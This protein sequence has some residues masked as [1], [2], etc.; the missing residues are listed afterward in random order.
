MFN[1]QQMKTVTTKAQLQ[2]LYL[3]E[4][5]QFRTYVA[6]LEQIEAGCSVTHFTRRA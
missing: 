2:E 4:D 1:L 3:E 6:M 5:F